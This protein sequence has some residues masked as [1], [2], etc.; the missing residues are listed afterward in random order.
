MPYVVPFGTR[1]QLLRRWLVTQREGLAAEQLAAAALA[2]WHNPI[3]VRR[4]SL[5]TDAYSELRGLG[6]GWRLPLRVRFFSAE[7]GEE[8]GVGEGIAKEFLVD[9]LREGFDPS[10]GLFAT[11]TEGGLYP[12][13]AARM[14]HAAV[15]A[16]ARSWYEFLGAVLAKALWEGILVELPLAPFFLSLLLGRTNTV[17][18]MPAFDAQLARSLRL[19]RD[20]DGDVEDLCLSFAV[21]QY[22]AEVPPELRRTHSLVPGGASLRVSASNRS[23]YILHL[24]HYRLNTQLR[25]A[26]DAFLRG[27]A[28]VVPRE[29]IRMFSVAELQLV[30]GGSDAPLNVADWRQ[31]ATYSGGYH[32]DSPPVR[33]F[34]QVLAEYPP[35][36]R[37]AALK[38]ATSCSRPPLMG[39]GWLQPPF[40]IHLAADTSRLPTSATCMN[41]LKLPPYGSLEA[42]RDKFTYAIE[43]GAGFELT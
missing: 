21:D 18:D 10:F 28:Q 40:C 24:S 6:R 26:A 36:R 33:W 42:L 20:Y 19:L 38:F 29:W 3:E 25:A 27:F 34:W 32:A 23:Q 17:H 13:P 12:D 4:G 30:L 11:G 14:S 5:L 31:H 43:A 1:L 16:S 22:T 9:V 37:A 15:G 41:L 8:A 7:G 35:P 2:G 39:F